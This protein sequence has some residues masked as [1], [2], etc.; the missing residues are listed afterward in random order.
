MR[1]S[2]ISRADRAA[3]SVLLEA[4]TSTEPA[5][6]KACRRSARLSATA[7]PPRR[8]R[9]VP[10]LSLTGGCLEGYDVRAVRFRYRVS[11]G[12][13]AFCAHA[14]GCGPAIGFLGPWLV[15]V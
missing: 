10:C 11:P 4:Q 13:R 15:P 9:Y 12:V 14:R 6:T 2:S 5:S 7:T 1:L 3:Q 8:R